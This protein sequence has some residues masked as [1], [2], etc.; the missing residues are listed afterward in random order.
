MK[1]GATQFTSIALMRLFE[2]LAIYLIAPVLMAVFL[3]SGMLFPA[4]IGFSAFGLILLFVTKEFQW[5]S[6]LHGASQI[7]MRTIVIASGLTALVGVVIVQFTQPE[8][9]FF[10]W[11]ERPGLMLMIALL[12]PLLSVLPQERPSDVLELDRRDPHLHRRPGLCLGL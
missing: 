8:A 1:H 4:L 12:Y 9:L 11:R 3:P 10:L 6:L 2:F 5:Y 7:T